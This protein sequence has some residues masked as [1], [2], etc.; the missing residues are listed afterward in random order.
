MDEDG[1]QNL[2]PVRRREHVTADSHGCQHH[3]RRQAMIKA[4]LQRYQWMP[5]DGETWIQ[6]RNNL[7]ALTNPPKPVPEPEPEPEPEDEDEWE[8]QPILSTADRQ[9]L[10]QKFRIPRGQPDPAWFDTIEIV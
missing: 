6:H 3:S 4:L 1:P 2:H 7:Q 10:R 5:R 9:A 8:P